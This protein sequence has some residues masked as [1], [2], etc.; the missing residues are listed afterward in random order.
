MSVLR[1]DPD[2]LA[3]QYAP[4]VSTG[5]SSP[6]DSTIAASAA[7]SSTRDTNT[8]FVAKSVNRKVLEKESIGNRFI[9]ATCW[10]R[11]SLCAGC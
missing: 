9:D 7:T 5:G 3:K 1:D 11:S 10:S 8:E 4:S 6:M 2:S